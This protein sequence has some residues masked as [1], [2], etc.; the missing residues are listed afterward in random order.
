MF[1]VRN[2]FKSLACYFQANCENLGGR[3]ADIKSMEEQRFIE[4]NFLPSTGKI[5]FCNLFKLIQLM[6]NVVLANL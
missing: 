4:D 1:Y 3:L 2:G 6:A 5:I